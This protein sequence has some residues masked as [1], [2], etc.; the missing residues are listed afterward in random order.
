MLPADGF[1]G[2]A[3]IDDYAPLV[4]VNTNA[5][6]EA[7]TFELMREFAHVLRGEPGISG[8]EAGGDDRCSRFALEILLPSDDLPR[9]VTSIEDAEAIAQSHFV[10][11]KAVLLS[12]RRHGAI[13]EAQFGRLWEEASKHPE[14]EGKASRSRAAKAI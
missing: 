8:G 2:F 3:A 7:R 4:F 10:D 6:M 5:A 14:A 12:A 1:S 11:C 13:D 9:A